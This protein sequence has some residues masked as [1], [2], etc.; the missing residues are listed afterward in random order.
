[1]EDTTKLVRLV[2]MIPVPLESWIH[3]RVEKNTA[4][5]N[6]KAHVVREILLN[7]KAQEE[8]TKK[9]ENRNV[10]QRGT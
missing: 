1:M 5:L 2:V 6:T 7:A 10:H 8:G 4:P 9:Q 3:K